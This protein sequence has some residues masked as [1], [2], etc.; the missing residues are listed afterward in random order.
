LIP[1]LGGLRE[2]LHHDLRE[3]LWDFGRAPRRRRRLPR[4]VAVHELHRIGRLEGRRA[5]QEL[6]EHRAERVEIG[7][8]VERP[9]HPAGLLRRHVR[10]RPFERVGALQLLRLEREARREPEAG[11]PHGEG[12]RIEE[13]VLGCDVLVDHAAAVERREGARG[14]EGDPQRGLEVRAPGAERLAH[15]APARIRH[16]ER[17]PVVTGAR[18]RSP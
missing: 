8:V 13:D 5:G 17:D 9:V 2:Q 6:V 18:R 1:L 4:D 3:D 16:D 11:E 10:E 7:A 12:R 14:A 15:R